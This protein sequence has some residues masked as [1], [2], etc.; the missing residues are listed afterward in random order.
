M[1]LKQNS[2]LNVKVFV[3]IIITEIPFARQESHNFSA[4][5]KNF[6]TQLTERK[7]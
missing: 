2:E 6:H 4:V 7:N 1:T 5:A 3:R